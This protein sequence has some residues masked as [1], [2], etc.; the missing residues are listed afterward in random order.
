MAT[1]ISRGKRQTLQLPQD[2]GHVSRGSSQQGS[3]RINPGILNEGLRARGVANQEKGCP[4]QVPQPAK[5]KWHNPRR[6]AGLSKPYPVYGCRFSVSRRLVGQPIASLLEA[7]FALAATPLPCVWRPPFE[8][9]AISTALVGK[10]ATSGY[11]LA[12]N[13]ATA[14]LAPPRAFFQISEIDNLRRNLML[15]AVVYWPKGCTLGTVR[16]RQ[17]DRTPHCLDR[18]GPAC[19]SRE[20]GGCS[21]H[22]IPNPPFFG[23]RPPPRYRPVNLCCSRLPR[24]GETPSR[25]PSERSLGGVSAEGPIV[26]VCHQ[27]S[28]RPQ[29]IVALILPISLLR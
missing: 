6:A 26:R 2:L 24:C 12:N 10:T 19:P 29:S 18:T 27:W 14:V 22:R 5:G 13:G 25:K 16:L 28:N 1:L 21:S 15:S 7:R 4:S 9:S 3:I 8:V 17:P 23:Q 11:P 20:G